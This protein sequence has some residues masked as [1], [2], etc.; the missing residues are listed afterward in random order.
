MRFLKKSL[1]E[2]QS[3]E[4]SSNKEKD[5][6]S[7]STEGE[8]PN[9]IPHPVDNV[10]PFPGVRGSPQ[11]SYVEIAEYVSG[12]LALDRYPV[13]YSLATNTNDPAT[14]RKNAGGQQLTGNTRVQQEEAGPMS[15]EK[16]KRVNISFTPSTRQAFEEVASENNMSLTEFLRR[17]GFAAKK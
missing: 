6:T 9:E 15:T 13:K 8:Q 12:S 11:L 3:E 2:V 5:K 17:A 4:K 1:R 14:V 7:E 16:P 10:S